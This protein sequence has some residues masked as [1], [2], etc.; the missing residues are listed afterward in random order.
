[1]LI[2]ALFHLHPHLRRH[3]HLRALHLSIGRWQ[4]ILWIAVIPLAW[5]LARFVYRRR[6]PRRRL[7]IG[8]LAAVAALQVSA[9]VSYGVW[10]NADV[11]FVLLWGSLVSLLAGAALLPGLRLRARRRPG[12]SP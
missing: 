6:P 10:R 5:A 9:Y 11:L 7:A 2:A 8:L 4:L 1:M 3:I 12:T